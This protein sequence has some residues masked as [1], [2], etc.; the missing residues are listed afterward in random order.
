MATHGVA[1]PLARRLTL[2]AAAGRLP[3]RP[4]SSG[5]RPCSTRV[6]ASQY[7]ARMRSCARTASSRYASAASKRRVILASARDAAQPIRSRCCRGSRCVRATASGADSHGRMGIPPMRGSFYQRDR[8]YDDD[9]GID[10]VGG[11]RK[12]VFM[13]PRSRRGLFGCAVLLAVTA[14]AA[15][16]QSG[17]QTIPLAPGQQRSAPPSTRQ[18]QQESPKV[19]GRRFPAPVRPPSP[20]V[21]PKVRVAVV[22]S[23]GSSVF[24]RRARSGGGRS[25]F[26]DRG[27]SGDGAS[28]MRGAGLGRPLGSR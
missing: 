4:R 23:G 8:A 7:G 12:G 9:V 26:G 22:S 25:G 11:T 28:Q 16:P 14:T 10:E 5:I 3:G 20:R 1:G 6:V 24:G 15:R 21:C 2:A 27:P 19:L 13:I 17:Q 18:P